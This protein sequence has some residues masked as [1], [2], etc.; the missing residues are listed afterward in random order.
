MFILLKSM[1]KKIHNI[2][3]EHNQ[4]SERTA[5]SNLETFDGR[6]SVEDQRAVVNKN[7]LCCS[8]KRIKAVGLFLETATLIGHQDY[9][10]L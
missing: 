6:G 10:I 9:A 3:C 8:I 4:P 1:S 7:M 2:C 5:R